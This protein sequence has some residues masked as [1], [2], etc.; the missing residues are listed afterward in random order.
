MKILKTFVLLFAMIF[1]LSCNSKS[2]ELEFEVTVGESIF[3]V[4][5]MTLDNGFGY[6]V[7]LNGKKM[8][9]QTVIPAIEGNHYF[10][11]REDALKVG[12]AVLMKMLKSSELPTITPEEIEELNIVIE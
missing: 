5:T 9:S 10:K 6:T 3:R 4:E 12:Q 1:V 2:K 7:A 11:T 8:I